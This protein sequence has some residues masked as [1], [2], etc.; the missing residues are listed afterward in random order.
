VEHGAAHVPVISELLFPAINFILFAWLLNRALAGPVREFFRER[1]E[2][3]REE[4]AAGDRAR[5][6]AEAL[7]AQLARELA[8]LPATREQLKADLLATA[9]RER[10]QLLAMA[11]Q[12]AERIRNDA[13]LLADQEVAAARRMLR[14]EVVE[15]AVAKASDLVRG[16]S[17]ADDQKRYVDEFVRGAG[18]LA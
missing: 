12:N 14:D 5:R 9:E 4:L 1:A 6:D 7:R 17:Q 15:G 2:R 8:E 10:D 3:L 11:K 13:R 16:S 18:A